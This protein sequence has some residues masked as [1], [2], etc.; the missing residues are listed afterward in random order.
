MYIVPYVFLKAL[1]YIA[2]CFVGVGWFRTSAASPR[3]SAVAFGLGRL[4]LGIALGFGIYIAALSMNNATRNAPLTYVAIYLP[5][6]GL[7]WSLWYFLLRDSRGDRRGPLWVTGGVVL[8]CLA[9]VPLGI[10][11]GGVVPVGRPFC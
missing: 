10:A 5:I 1:A 4:A 2:W 6:R 9:D 11:E 8:S 3:R 7:E